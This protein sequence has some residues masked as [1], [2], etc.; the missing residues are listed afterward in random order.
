LAGLLGGWAL[1]P[2]VP[3][4]KRIWTASFA[5][6]AAGWTCLMLAAFFGLIDGLRWRR[7]AFPLI[8]AGMN[9][10]A[11]YVSAGIFSGNIK[12]AVQPFLDPLFL[13]DRYR[14]FRLSLGM[15]PTSAP[16]TPEEAVLL[17]V[18]VVVGQWLFCYWLYRQKIFF[19]V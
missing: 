11:L 10:I 1:S 3:L 16:I 14:A 7:W 18:L 2:W 8:V 4:V 6:F 19:K 13:W 5:I 17:A 15:A 12:K 9:S